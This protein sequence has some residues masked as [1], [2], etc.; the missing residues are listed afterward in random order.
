MCNVSMPKMIS[1]HFLHV[2]YFRFMLL[3]FTTACAKI[4]YHHHQKKCSLIHN[5]LLKGWCNMIQRMRDDGLCHLNNLK[6][7]S[8][9]GDILLCLFTSMAKYHKL[10]P[11]VIYG[12][13]NW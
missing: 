12:V 10:L 8:F 4:H 2:V 13:S 11:D 5:L 3:L 1:P 6:I 9:S 7:K